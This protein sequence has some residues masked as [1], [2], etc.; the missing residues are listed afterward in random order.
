MAHET[1]QVPVVGDIFSIGIK[2][3]SMS[4]FKIVDN[5]VKESG[6]YQVRQ[7]WI[8]PNLLGRGSGVTLRMWSLESTEYDPEC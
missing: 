5:T 2:L 8:G 6:Y 3:L 7:D 4:V 1:V